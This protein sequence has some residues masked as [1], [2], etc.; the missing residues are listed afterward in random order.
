MQIGDLVVVK[1]GFPSEG[2]V[3][4]VLTV[5]RW[6]GGADHDVLFPEDVKNL[7]GWWLERL[8]AA[9]ATR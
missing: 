9:D 1:E 5:T 3:G 8:E 2:Q 4:V 6:L 7:N